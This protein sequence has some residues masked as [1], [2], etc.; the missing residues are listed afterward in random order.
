MTGLDPLQPVTAAVRADSFRIWEKNRAR[1]EQDIVEGRPFD[2]FVSE[3]GRFDAMFDFLLRSGLWTAAT[4][5]RPSGLKKNNGISYRLLNGVECL[6]EMAGI[7][8]PA[9]CGPL[10]KDAYLLERIGFTAG[11][12]QK[13]PAQERTGG[14]PEKPLKQLG[15][16]TGKSF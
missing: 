16:F 11:K 3:R 14:D 10:L 15:A 6:R 1:V 13:H 7:D 9:N 4:E 12:K 2:A 5:M 8:P